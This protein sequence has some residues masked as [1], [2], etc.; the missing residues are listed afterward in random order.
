MIGYRLALAFPGNDQAV[1]TR[2]FHKL[3]S[4]QLGG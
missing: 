3:S 4:S 2:K 1:L